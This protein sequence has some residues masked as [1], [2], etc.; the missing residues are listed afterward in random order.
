[1]ALGLGGS[2]Y[3]EPGRYTGPGGIDYGTTPWGGQILE[4]NP[5]VAYYRYG[6]EMGVPDDNSAFGQWFRRQFPQFNLG[7]GAY[8]VSNPLEANIVDYTKSLGGYGDWMRQY[9]AQDP[10]LRG[11]DPSA[12]GAGPARWIGR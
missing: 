4:Q 9:Q 10:R 6:R 12:R 1:M 7:Y 8:T 2:P 5:D 11:E 3:W